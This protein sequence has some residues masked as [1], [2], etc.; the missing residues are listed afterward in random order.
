MHPPPEPSE[1]WYPGFFWVAD[2]ISARSH[3]RKL[4]HHGQNGPFGPKWPKMVP[5]LDELISAYVLLVL[6][7]NIMKNTD[8]DNFGRFDPISGH[9]G[10]LYPAGPIWAIFK[11]EHFVAVFSLIL[12]WKIWKKIF[13][14]VTRL[15]L[16]DFGP[17]GRIGPTAP[18]WLFSKSSTSSHFFCDFTLKNNEK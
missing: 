12:G 6:G 2:F 16:D 4:G 3:D 5:K 1:I 8:F 18:K 13:F 15:F 11:I 7:W 14:I 17:N 9:F 10:P